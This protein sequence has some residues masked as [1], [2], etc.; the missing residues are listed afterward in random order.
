MPRRFCYECGGEEFKDGLCKQHFAETHKLIELPPKIEIEKCS[1]CTTIKDRNKRVEWDPEKFF[2]KLAG[3]EV[4]L[5]EEKKGKDLIYTVEVKGKTAGVERVETA[6]TRIHFDVRICERCG[7]IASDYYEGILQLR[8][9]F[10]DDVLNW[11]D[12]EI[13]RSKDKMVFY[14]LKQVKGGVDVYLG[15][16]RFLKRLAGK[17]SKKHKIRLVESFKQVTQIEGREIRR[18]IILA[19]FDKLK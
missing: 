3:M 10:T 7:K 9:K 5:T 18:R 15:S 6:T 1:K 4:K 2:S 13:G 12:E 8:G 14:R 11:I 17:L 16:Q 19:R